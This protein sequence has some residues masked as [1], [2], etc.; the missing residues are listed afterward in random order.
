MGPEIPYPRKG[1]RTR[2]TYPLE[3]TWYQDT[4][5]PCGQTDTCENITIPQ[6]CWQSATTT[7]TIG[8]TSYQVADHTQ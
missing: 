6:L 4:L 3:R 8:R 7:K 5:P 1:H 2:D